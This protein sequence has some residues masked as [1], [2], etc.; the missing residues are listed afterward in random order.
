MTTIKTKITGIEKVGFMLFSS[1]INIVFNFW[2]L[3][4]LIFLTNVLKI[5]V[6]LAGVIMTIGIIWDGINDPLFGYLCSKV[7]FKTKEKIR[8][9]LKYAS[10]PWAVMLVL[11]F[12]NFK[13]NSIPAAILSCI[14]Y[15]IFEVFSSVMDI[16]YNAM[17]GLAS[18]ID[19]DRR[20]INSFRSL[21]AGLGSAIG[22]VAVTPLVTMFGGLQGENAIVSEADAMPLFLTSIVMGVICVLGALFLYFTT[23]ERVQQ[24]NEV[25]D[26]LSFVEAWKVLFR[27]NSWV[28]NMIYI[29]CYTVSNNIIMTSIN[30]YAAYVLGSSSSATPIL[31]VYLVVFMVGSVLAPK[32]SEKLGGK[33]VATLSACILIAGKIPFIFM[34]TNVIMMYIN[35]AS[36]GLGAS[37]SYICFNTNRNNISDI[38]EIQNN[39]RL[40]SMV[41]SA[42]NLASKFGNALVTQLIT[43]TL[44]L[45]GFKESLKLNQTTQT[46]NSICAMLGWIPLVI[47]IIM[48]IVVRK[49]DTEKE[50]KEAIGL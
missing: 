45:S 26:N 48:L 22:A 9:F 31:A 4:Y 34:P 7:N 10:I 8:P 30:Y 3:F 47:A 43:I 33:Q 28:K 46:I 39:R 40:D 38:V 6:Y 17:G 5:P 36:I 20:K 15:L 25:T 14:L 21:G 27:C 11:L 19:L 42:D 44:A 1:S 32:L 24:K 2:N 29:T 16:P 49:I 13:L 50:K 37:L 23:K 12:T 18:D 35:A 41:S